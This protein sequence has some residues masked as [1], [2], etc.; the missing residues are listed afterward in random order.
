[1]TCNSALP[2][3][4]TSNARLTVG[5]PS[6]T[7]NM[8]HVR[9][10]LTLRAQTAVSLWRA[11]LPTPSRSTQQPAHPNTPQTP[12]STGGQTLEV[13]LASPSGPSGPLAHPLQSPPADDALRSNARWR[14]SGPG[15]GKG[16]TLRPAS[17][18]PFALRHARHVVPCNAHELSSLTTAHVC[19]VHA[20][21][22][23]RRYPTTNCC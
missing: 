17:S 20:Q 3:M 5:A 2:R 16:G 10:M 14:R 19:S 1:M 15:E 7:G 12:P 23:G 18:L 11:A 13:N 21:R 6:Y 8:P 4:H 22:C 9:K